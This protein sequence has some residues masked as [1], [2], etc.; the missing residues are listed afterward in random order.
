MTKHVIIHSWS[1]RTALSAI[2]MLAVP[3]ASETFLQSRLD[4]NSVWSSQGTRNL[5]RRAARTSSSTF[6]KTSSTY[7]KKKK[8]MK[9]VHGE[10]S[11][12]YEIRKK[13]LE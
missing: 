11:T 12:S 5:L 1:S 6:Q 8:D 13:I 7:E 4:S 3:M 2:R 10:K 9:K